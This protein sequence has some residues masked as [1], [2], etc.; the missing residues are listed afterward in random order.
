MAYP[1]NYK[2]LFSDHGSEFDEKVMNL[3]VAQLGVK[4]I[5]TSRYSPRGNGEIERRWRIMKAHLKRNTSTLKDI[6]KML[7]GFVFALNCSKNETTQFRLH[8]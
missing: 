6:A 5:R 1:K 4:R 7:P 2:E 8:F 3:L